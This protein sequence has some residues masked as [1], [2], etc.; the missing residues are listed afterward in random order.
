M[1]VV[2]TTGL[3]PGY[4]ISRVIKGGWQL[5]GDHGEVHRD[6]A[7]RDGSARGRRTATPRAGRRVTLALRRGSPLPSRH[8]PHRRG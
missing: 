5:A 2:E 8:A 7:T 1:T 4:G 6:A 3:R